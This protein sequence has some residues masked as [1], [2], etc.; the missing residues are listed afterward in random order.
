MNHSLLQTDI[1]KYVREFAATADIEPLHSHHVTYLAEQIFDQLIS[2]HQC[3]E[4]ERLLLVCASLLHDIGWQNG[5]QKHH[6]RSMEMI[7]SQTDW[8]WSAEQ[9]LIVALI[10]R[11]HRKAL[12]KK[13]HPGYHLLKPKEQLTVC[14]LASLLRIADGLDRRHM[15]TVRSVQIS[16]NKQKVLCQCLCQQPAE[17]ELEFAAKKSDLFQKTFNLPIAFNAVDQCLKAQ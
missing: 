6:K 4:Q 9:R 11:Y 1:L 17:P 8:P 10:A 13:K 3:S 15:Q 12:P 7:L 5:R 2:L 14:K 16:F